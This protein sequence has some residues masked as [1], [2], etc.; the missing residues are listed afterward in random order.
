MTKKKSQFG[1]TGLFLPRNKIMW[2]QNEK[3]SIME[4]NTAGVI[5]AELMSP[6]QFV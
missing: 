2:W 5:A 1:R 6:R 4:S 3:K